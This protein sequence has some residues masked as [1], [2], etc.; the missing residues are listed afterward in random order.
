MLTMNDWSCIL[1]HANRNVNF[2]RWYSGKVISMV[3]D[4]KGTLTYNPKLPCRTP[5]LKLPFSS[6]YCK[7]NQFFMDKKILTV[8]I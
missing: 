2:D 7:I 6:G 4:C 3:M 1:L 8:I 5:D